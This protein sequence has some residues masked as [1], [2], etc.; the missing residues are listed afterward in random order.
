VS[1]LM[2][3]VQFYN[4]YVSKV[5]PEPTPPADSYYHCDG[6]DAGLNE[7]NNTCARVLKVMAGTGFSQQNLIIGKPAAEC[8]VDD[9]QLCTAAATATCAG[10]CTASWTPNGQQ[11]VAYCAYE[12]ISCLLPRVVVVC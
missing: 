12:V 1:K 2:A 10:M 9:K 6:S 5:W 8:C 7:V 11:P 4:C 3:S